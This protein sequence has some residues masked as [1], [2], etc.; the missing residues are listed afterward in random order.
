[1]RLYK[2]IYLMFYFLLFCTSVHTANHYVDKNATGHN[3]GTSWRNAW[4]SF[5]DIEWNQM[6]P[7]DIVY[8]SGGTDSTVYYEELYIGD[9]QGTA[10]NPITIKNSYDAGHNGRVII[11]ASQGGGRDCLSIGRSPGFSTDYITI[12]GLELR[13][14]RYG[15]FIQYRANTIIIDSMTVYDWTYQGFHTAGKKVPEDIDGITIQNSSWISPLLGSG[16]DCITTNTS[17]NHIIRN[18]FI[19]QRNSKVTNNHVDGILSLWSEGF[20]IYNNVIIVDSNAQGQA[21]ILAA[22]ADAADEDSIIIYNN[23]IFQGGIWNS[24][25]FPWTSVV[26]LRWNGGTIKPPAFVAHNTIVSNGRYVQG[27]VFEYPATL[28][29]NIVA[30]FGDGVNP[31]S[32]YWLENLRNSTGTIYVDSIRSNILWREWTGKWTGNRNRTRAMFTGTWHG[33]LTSAR[34]FGWSKWRGTLRGT[35]I[36]AN[37][38]FVDQI[39]YIG[40]QSTLDGELKSGSPAINA[41]EDIQAIIERMGLPWTDI[42]GNPRDSTPDIGA[43]EYVH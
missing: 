28:V 10:G 8:I 38:L 18:N 9:V 22:W 11:D 12:S 33:N 14:G 13:N 5:S 19:H 4:E 27:F 43:Y 23:Y 39:G 30:Q 29:N 41:G 15:V 32:D 1:M 31:A 42:N 36:N 7:G 16:G 6:Q 26:N 25:K 20:K 24:E 17:S 37:P 35:G 34:N 21:I 2:I 3:N 40:D